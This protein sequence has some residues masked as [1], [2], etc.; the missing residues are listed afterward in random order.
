MRFPFAFVVIFV[1]ATIQQ[2]ISQ[3]VELSE[4]PSKQDDKKDIVKI[5]TF[6]ERFDS[7]E[8]KHKTY[9]PDKKL[10]AGFYRDGWDEIISIHDSHSKKQIKRFL[11]NGD[12]V[13]KFKFTANGKLIATF[14]KTR[15]WK[16]W[17]VS[18]GKL[19]LELPGS[20]AELELKK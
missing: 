20:P 10:Y 3:D 17:D 8:L 7:V 2:G 12:N 19:L 6:G 13:S 1:L 16:V 11:S 4:K 18:S 9:S 14:A 5:K 15:G